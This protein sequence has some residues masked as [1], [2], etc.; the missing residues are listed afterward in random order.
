ERLIASRRAEG[1]EATVRGALFRRGLANS[2]KSVEKSPDDS[3]RRSIQVFAKVTEIRRNCHA[4]PRVDARIV[5]EGRVHRPDYRIEPDSSAEF[6]RD[7]QEYTS[8]RRVD[9]VT[10]TGVDLFRECEV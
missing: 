2:S 6:R 9:G 7:A 1:N 5:D 4:V 3:W 8:L 10:R